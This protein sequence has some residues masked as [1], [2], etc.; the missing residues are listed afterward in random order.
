MKAGS[1]GGGIDTLINGTEANAFRASW[2]GEC[3]FYPLRTVVSYCHGQFRHKSQLHELLNNVVG[4]VEAPSGVMERG[5]ARL[6]RRV[7]NILTSQQVP[8]LHV[9]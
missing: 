8:L 7:F 1:V 4:L 5:N 2:H 6:W 3:P 9:V